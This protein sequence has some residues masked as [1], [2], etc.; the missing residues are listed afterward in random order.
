MKRCFIQ[1]TKEV[2]MIRFLRKLTNLNMWGGKHTEIKN[3]LKAL[4][5][6]LRGEKVTDEAMKELFRLEFLFSKPS[7]GEIHI[8]LNP[9]KKKEISEFLER[10]KSLLK[11]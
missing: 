10:N 9:R 6:H 11:L 8:S 2:I 1:E 3:L 4:P 5:K 7:T